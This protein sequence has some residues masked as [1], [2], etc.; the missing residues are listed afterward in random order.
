MLFGSFWKVLEVAATDS[1]HESVGGFPHIHTSGASPILHPSRVV[2]RRSV[3]S[4]KIF[5]CPRTGNGSPH[6][7]VSLV[8]RSASEC[9]ECF[10]HAR[11][12]RAGLRVRNLLR[13]WTKPRNALRHL[14]AAVNQFFSSS[15][16]PFIA[17]NVSSDLLNKK[18]GYQRKDVSRRRDFVCDKGLPCWP[19]VGA[20]CL[21]DVF[22]FVSEE[23]RD[24]VADPHRCLLPESQWP[25][26]TS[27][28]RMHAQDSEWYSLVKACQGRALFAEVAE[29]DMGEDMPKVRSGS[30]LVSFNLYFL[31]GEPFFWSLGGDALHL[32]HHH[33]LSLVLLDEDEILT[34][35][36]QDMQSC[37]NF[38]KMPACWSG[39]FAFD[40]ESI[41]V[42]LRAHVL[43][44]GVCCIRAVPMAWIGAVVVMLCM[45]SRFVF[46]LSGSPCNFRT[47]ETRAITRSCRV[48]GRL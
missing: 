41:R 22:T 48:Y 38:S 6:H 39:F 42:G 32:S 27:N 24:K 47:S 5:R 46:G 30:R 17:Q 10:W 9:T 43:R 40:K 8:A 37:F 33:Q 23:L 25:Q 1:V 4:Q 18:F 13:S 34:V 28:S 11:A 26:V 16:V 2:S 21:F 44:Y 31:P 45:A 35:D 15:S 14:R 36:S 7:A 19:G 3:D 29:K 12:G 20:A